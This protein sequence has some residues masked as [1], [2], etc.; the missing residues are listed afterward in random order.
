M[1]KP[2]AE[3]EALAAAASAVAALAGDG[4]APGT[5]AVAI[6]LDGTPPSRR[7]AQ[8]HIGVAISLVLVAI[9]IAVVIRPFEEPPPRPL[10]PEELIV[11]R[12]TALVAKA[13]AEKDDARALALVAETIALDPTTVD[14]RDATVERVRRSLAQGRIDEA[15]ADVA[16]LQSRADAAAIDAFLS[17]SVTKIEQL[18]GSKSGANDGSG[19]SPEPA[20]HPGDRTFQ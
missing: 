12:Q 14:A 18:A 19:V 17:E 8:L 16:V 10:T 5:A 7:A 3:P 15:K 1:K 20:G 6:E 11:V 4:P 2:A 9:A 13:R